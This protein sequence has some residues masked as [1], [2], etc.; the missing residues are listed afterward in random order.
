MA[1]QEYKIPLVFKIYIVAFG[2]YSVYEWLLNG[3]LSAA[4]LPALGLAV[5]GILVFLGPSHIAKNFN[6]VVHYIFAVVLS[7]AA[8]IMRDVAPYPAIP[9]VAA[10]FFGL[11]CYSIHQWKPIGT[12]ESTDTSQ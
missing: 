8:V 2:L 6:L 5:G 11:I 3:V 4:S 9:T 1:E 7:V 12:V 10:I